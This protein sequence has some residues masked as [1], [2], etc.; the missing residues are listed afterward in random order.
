MAKLGLFI[1]DGDPNV[2]SLTK[3]LIGQITSQGHK[4]V[5]TREQAELMRL[6]KYAASGMKEFNDVEFIV[7]VGGDGTMLRSARMFSQFGLPI[8]GINLGRRGFLTE[9]QISHLPK[10]LPKILKGDYHVDERMMLEV[11]I[12]RFGKTIFTTGALN[13][14][15]IGKNGLARIIRLKAYINEKPI[16]TY[17]GDGLIISTPTGSTGHNLSA[18]GPIIDASLSAFVLTSICPL[19]MANRPV[20]LAGNEALIVT[21][22]EVPKGMDGVL[23]ADGQQVISIKP[24]D[25]IFIKKSPYTTRFIRMKDYNFFNVLKEKLGWGEE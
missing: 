9:I 21:V 6:K 17:A 16:T 3:K 1:K 22:L 25:E 8:L 20:I 12:K 18:G 7:S 24:D 13:D 11:I 15:V 23:T 10:A 19:T 4:V 2:T 5:L 14:I